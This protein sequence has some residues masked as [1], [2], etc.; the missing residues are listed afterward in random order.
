MKLFTRKPKAEDTPARRHIAD[1]VGRTLGTD[2]RVTAIRRLS[3]HEGPM[4][5]TS[6]AFT[7]TF[8]HEGRTTYCRVVCYG[9]TPAEKMVKFGLDPCE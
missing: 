5:G 6:D 7:F 3:D 9:D 8:A 2:P 1:A 4:G